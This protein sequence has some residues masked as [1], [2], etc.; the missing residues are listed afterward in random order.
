[1]RLGTVDPSG[2][3]GY[4]FGDPF[5]RETPPFSGTFT[6]PAGVPLTQKMMT[7]EAWAIDW[8][9]GNGI[10]DV[11]I[12][13]PIIPKITTFKAVSNVIA[14]A[15]VIGLA[16]AK[17]GCFCSIVPMQ[18]WRSKLGLPTVAPKNIV[19]DPHYKAKFGNRKTFKKD[20]SRQYLKDKAMELARKLGSDPKDDNEGDAICIWHHIATLKRNKVDVPSF[21]FANDLTI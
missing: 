15:F 19:L 1:M 17:C 8:I 16:A 10:T 11:W 20:A 21:D 5:D 9:K 13:E 6:L 7:A 2:V 18:T 3:C 14:L 12:E 4:A